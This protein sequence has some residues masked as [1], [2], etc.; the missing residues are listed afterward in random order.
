MG[1][2]LCLC[3]FIIFV[4]YKNTTFYLNAFSLP[5]RNADTYL[6]VSCSHVSIAK[7]VHSHRTMPNSTDS[8]RFHFF[9]PLKCI[10]VTSSRL[11]A[12]TDSCNSTLMEAMIRARIYVKGKIFVRKCQFLTIYAEERGRKRVPFR[13]REPKDGET[14]CRKGRFLEKKSFPFLFLFYSVCFLLISIL[15]NRFVK[16]KPMFM[17][18]PK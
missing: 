16:R 13:W 2:C 12:M 4:C 1:S 6:Q 8:W 11:L 17:R 7:C 9:L 14:K 3:L 15:Q 18:S 10:H 5:H